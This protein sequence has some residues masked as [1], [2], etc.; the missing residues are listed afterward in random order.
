VKRL[1]SPD[2][3]D[4]V[5]VSFDPSRGH[6][7]Q[8]TRPALVLSNK[9]FNKKTR[10]MQVLPITST[11]PR[12]AMEIK[13]PDGLSVKGTIQCHQLRTLD[14]EERHAE[15]IGHCPIDTVGKAQAIATAILNQ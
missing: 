3:G 6:E 8:K 11:P 4:I 5:F 14:W 13:L 7:Q 2:R 12:N 15:K 1:F 9:N 10:L